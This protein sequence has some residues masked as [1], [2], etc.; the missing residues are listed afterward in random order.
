MLFLRNPLARVK[1][2]A[3]MLYHHILFHI[4][5]AKQVQLDKQFP[6]MG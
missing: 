3:G 5:V 6:E 4:M 1:I 2:F